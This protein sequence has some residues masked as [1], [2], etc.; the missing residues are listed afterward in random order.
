MGKDGRT[1]Q[2]S[3]MKQSP[4][5]ADLSGGKASAESLTPRRSNFAVAE[6]VDFQFNFFSLAVPPG[7]TLSSVQIISGT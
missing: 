4:P 7:L 6:A 3:R 2:F 5:A 1:S